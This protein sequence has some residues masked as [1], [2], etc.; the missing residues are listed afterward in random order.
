MRNAEFACI[1]TRQAAAPVVPAVAAQ[2]VEAAELVMGGSTA[3]GITR[4]LGMGV[5]FPLLLA[6][7]ASLFAGQRGKNVTRDMTVGLAAKRLW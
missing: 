7:L 4:L 6:S 1:G 5:K 2:V 3:C